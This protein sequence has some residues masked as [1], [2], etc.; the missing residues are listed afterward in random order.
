MHILV[1]NDD[2][3]QAQGLAE[4]LKA[5]GRTEHKITVVVPSQN[6]SGSGQSLS[7]FN[8]IK[9][10]EFDKNFY[11]VEGTPADCV[12]I[13]SHSLVTEPVDIVISGINNTANLADDVPYSGT[14]A[15]ALEGRRSR[16][17]SIAV[18]INS[19]RPNHFATAGLVVLDLLQGLSALP[20]LDNMAILNVNVPD[21]P[22]EDITQWAV[23]SLGKRNK[24]LTPIKLR[25]V[26]NVQYY[27]LGAC[28]DFVRN[29]D[30]QL[31]LDFEVLEQGGVSIT[32]LSSQL[33]HQP[34]MSDI[35]DWLID[36][37]KSW[38]PKA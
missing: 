13:G 30:M 11:I 7:L 15:A 25:E 4:L 19:R 20:K 2:G 17:P 27:Q 12:Y 6:R 8:E 5:L 10:S 34:F 37:P 14:V 26:D 23:T 28:G 24:A 33:I 1:S 38:E 32:P 22:Y 18:S 29:H 36:L 16:F 9:V 3:Y 31:P 35:S 21:I